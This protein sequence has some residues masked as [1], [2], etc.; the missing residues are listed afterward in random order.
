MGSHYA[1]S[2]CAGLS[3]TLL[4]GWRQG[5]PLQPSPYQELATRSGSTL[6]EVLSLCQRLNHEGRLDSVHACWGDRLRRARWLHGF[7]SPVSERQLAELMAVHGCVGLERVQQPADGWPSLWITL[8]GRCDGVVQEQLVACGLQPGVSIPLL[9]S[10]GHC[11][12]DDGP[13]T[14]TDLA[15]AVEEGLPLVAH[16]YQR[17]AERLGRSERQVLARLREWQLRG[18]LQ[19]LSLAAPHHAPWQACASAWVEAPRSDELLRHSNVTTLIAG[20]ALF[21]FGTGPVKGFAVV[22]V[23]GILTSMFSAV[24]VSRALINIIYGYRRKIEKLAV[25]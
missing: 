3:Q 4:H 12:C 9:R 10:D 18:D 19:A 14:D 20:L 16:P 5:F 6:R 23:L 24:L 25:G 17:L 13:C 1:P 8:E 22:H 15:H 7:S 21:M 11:A 2:V